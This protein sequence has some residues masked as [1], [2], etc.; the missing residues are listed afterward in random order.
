MV[1]VVEMDEEQ[2]WLVLMKDSDGLPSRCRRAFNVF[3]DV[4]HARLN[5]AAKAIPIVDAGYFHLR[6]L[7]AQHTENG[8]KYS[9]WTGDDGRDVE[10]I[11]LP[12]V[13]SDA[14]LL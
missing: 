2:S 8:G 1:H 11:G 14:V 3:Q 7:F 9:A 6:F 5:Q 4:G 13:G 12:V 10:F